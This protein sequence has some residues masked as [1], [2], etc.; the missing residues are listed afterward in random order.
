[1]TYLSESDEWE[2]PWEVYAEITSIYN[3]NPT[4]DVC[5][6]EQNAMLDN[7]FTKKD[8]ALNQKWD[9]KN[10]CNVPNSR[11]NKELFTKKAHE[12]FVNFGNETLMIMP[13]DSL[14][15]KYAREYILNN[16]Y[17]YEPRTTRIQFLFEGEITEFGN[18]KKG[19]ASVFFGDFKN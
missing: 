11:P 6:T 14:C 19:Y 16:N 5:A 8:N 12:E 13:I 10:W 17:H 3:F 7:F 2:T 4:L 9:K 15:T 1:M 18:S